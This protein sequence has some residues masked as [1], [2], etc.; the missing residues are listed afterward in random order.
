MK[1]SSLLGN[2]VTRDENRIETQSSLLDGEKAHPSATQ[3]SNR[4]EL[5]EFSA[6]NL[7]TLSARGRSRFS[8]TKKCLSAF[9]AYFRL[10]KYEDAR[11]RLG[12]RANTT[13]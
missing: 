8:Q 12:T 9:F 13:S 4:I 3:T 5:S 10:Y 6:I 2:V 11:D 7:A 1:K